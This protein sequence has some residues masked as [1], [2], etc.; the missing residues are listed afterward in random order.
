MQNSSNGRKR[1]IAGFV[2]KINVVCNL[3]LQDI[4]L[5]G[6]NV[7]VSILRGRISTRHKESTLMNIDEYQE[8]MNLCEIIN[9]NTSP[10]VSVTGEIGFKN[11]SK[12]TIAANK[13]IY[14]TIM[15]NKLLKI[16]NQNINLS[17]KFKMFFVVSKN[18]SKIQWTRTLKYDESRKIFIDVTL[19]HRVILVSL[20]CFFIIFVGKSF[21]LPKFSTSVS[22]AK[23]PT[24]I[25]TNKETYKPYTKD[26]S[27][28]FHVPET[29]AQYLIQKHNVNRKT[30]KESIKKE[31]QVTCVIFD[32]GE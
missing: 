7:R 5:K 18:K 32:Q 6:L 10:E 3:K 30:L 13:P 16:I 28:C 8:L 1:A 17:R 22:S 12:I 25:T 15:T 21:I 9:N 27:G 24:K 19:T 11:I 31:H 14:K 2:K 20:L 26:S 29:H 23:Q 4:Q